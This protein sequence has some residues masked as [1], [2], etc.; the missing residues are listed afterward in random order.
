MSIARPR[1]RRHAI[2]RASTRLGLYTPVPRQQRHGPIHL[3]RNTP[4]TRLLRRHH[5]QIQSDSKRHKNARSTHAALTPALADAIWHV[6]RAPGVERF[7]DE[8]SGEFYYAAFY[9]GLAFIPPTRLSLHYLHP[10]PFPPPLASRSCAISFA[11]ASARRPP[12]LSSSH[13]PCASFPPSTP[14]LPPLVCIAPVSVTCGVSVLPTADGGAAWRDGTM[15]YRTRMDAGGNAV[16][17]AYLN[18]ARARWCIVSRRHLCAARTSFTQWV[19]VRVPALPSTPTS[20]SPSPSSPIFTLFFAL[21]PP[22]RRRWWPCHAR[23]DSGGTDAGVSPPVFLL[24][25][26]LSFPCPSSILFAPPFTPSFS[27]SQKST[28]AHRLP[29]VRHE[30]VLRA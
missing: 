4:R 2:R 14:A 5:R 23:A 11:C 18:S 17:A 27:S 1:R 24:P 8:H 22:C 20:S 28:A 12:F 10:L 6:A 29:H 9:P 21:F 13:F 30:D 26:F 7:V 15:S 19:R 3:Q 25:F 16:L